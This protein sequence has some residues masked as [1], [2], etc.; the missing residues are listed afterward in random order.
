M[1]IDNFTFKKIDEMTAREFYC[2]ER[3]RNT[4]FVA[5]QKITL[6]DLDDEDLIAVQVYL[7]NQK[8]TTALATCRLFQEDGKWM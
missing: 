1:K 5:E 8:Q 7:L 3:L 2:V 4:T 6:P